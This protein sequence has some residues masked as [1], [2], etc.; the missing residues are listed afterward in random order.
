MPSIINHPPFELHLPLNLGRK[1]VV[2]LDVG[3][4]WGFSQ[5][6]FPASFVLFSQ[7]SLPPLDGILYKHKILLEVFVGIMLVDKG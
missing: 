3:R 6:S 1:N 4:F 7:L 5:H 2:D